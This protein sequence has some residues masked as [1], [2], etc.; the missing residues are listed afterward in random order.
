MANVGRLR[1]WKGQADF[2]DAA[3]RVRSP[4]F[5]AVVGGRVFSDGEAPRYGDELV[6][7]SDA[8]GIARRVVFT[9]QRDD[10]SD[11]WPHFALLVHTARAEPFGRVVAEAQCA[12]VPVVA[13]ADGGV[14]EIVR[15]GETGLLVP[16]GDWEAAARAV[17]DLLQDPAR[18]E[19]MGDAARRSAERFSPAHHASALLE[20]YRRVA[21]AGGHPG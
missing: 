20:V 15:H 5:F 19:A 9:G 1:P 13:Y 14:P 16:A 6:E 8:L 3:A 2:L 11:L 7:R 17:D 4:A 12:G 18:R 21:S 10:L